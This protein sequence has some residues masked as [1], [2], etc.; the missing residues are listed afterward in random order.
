[1]KRSL[2]FFLG[3]LSGVISIILYWS[4]TH[5]N[6]VSYNYED[7]ETRQKVIAILDKNNILYSY[8]ID[9]LKRHWIIPQIEDEELFKE[10]VGNIDAY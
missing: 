10:L 5:S 9:H 1:M 6:Y 2:Y 7:S 8:Q 3:Y 4:F